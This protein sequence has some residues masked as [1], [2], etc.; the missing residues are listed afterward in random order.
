MS[1]PDRQTA[2][3]KQ[4]EAEAIGVTASKRAVGLKSGA[5]AGEWVSQKVDRSGYLPEELRITGTRKAEPQ[6]VAAAAA[7]ATAGVGAGACAPW[8]SL[9]SVR[10]SE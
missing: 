10:E 5:Q 8:P 9:V 2:L 6:S 1:E 3:A 4:P 7:T